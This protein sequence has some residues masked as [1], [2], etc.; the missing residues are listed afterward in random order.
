MSIEEIKNKKLVFPTEK[1][2]LSQKGQGFL[3]RRTLAL[4]LTHP[5]K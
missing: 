3:D 1:V 5:Y 4:S 2:T